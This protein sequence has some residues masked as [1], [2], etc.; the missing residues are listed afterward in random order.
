MRLRRR[1][2]GGKEH[3]SAF[4]ASK[5]I[6][7]RRIKVDVPEHFTLLSTGGKPLPVSAV[8]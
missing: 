4:R 3:W 1:L 8:T 5:W 6:L 7:L 2:G